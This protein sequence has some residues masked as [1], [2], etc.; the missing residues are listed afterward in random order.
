MPPK[1]ESRIILPDAPSDQESNPVMAWR[2]AVKIDTYA[3]GEPDSFPAFLERRVYQGSSGR[4]YPLPFRERIESVKEPLSWDAVHLE[5]NWVRLM[6]LPALGGRIHIGMDKTNGYDFFYRNN[7]VKPALVGLTGPWVSGGVE[8]NWPQ[9]H[10]PTTFLPTG[11]AIEREPDGAITVW[12][13]DHDPFARMKGMH[14]VRLRP[15][16]CLIELRVRLFNRSEDV[17]TFLWWANIAAR[18]GDRY[19]SF[20][21]A[22]VRY[23]AD[24]ARRATTRFPHA[25]RPYY[26]VDYPARAAARDPDADRLDWYRNITVPTSY[27]C[28]NSRGDFFGGYDHERQAGFVHWADHRIAPGKKQWTW[29]NAP[30]GWAWDANLTDGGGPYVELM[31]GVFTDN[32]PDFSYLVPGETRCFSQF[33]YPIQRI[34]PV[35]Q[36]TL[37]EAVRLDVEPAEDGTEVRVAVAVTA[38]RPVLGVRLE[39]PE[40]R[41]VWTVIAHAAPD[42]P[43]VEQVRLPGRYAPTELTLVIHRDGSDTLRW[44]HQGDTDV[45]EVPEPAAEPPS[46]GAIDSIEELYLTGLH[47]EQY[48]HATR[49]PEP[50]WRE[51]LARDP[52]YAAANLA[53]ARRR[54][55]AAEYAEAERHLRRALSRQTRLNAN[56]RDGE[57]HYLLGQVLRRQHRDADAY[58]A[59]AK[60]AWNAAWRVPAWLAMARLDAAAGRHGRALTLLDAMLRLDGEHLQ[61]RDLKALVLRRLGRDAEADGV[62]AATLAIDPLDSWARDLA[63]DRAAGDPTIG[64]DVALEYAAAGETPAALRILAAVADAPTPVGQVNVAPLAHYHRADLLYRGGDPVAARDCARLAATVDATNCL[65][66][67]LDD[68]DMLE[69]RCATAPRD[70]RAWALLGHWRYSVRRYADAVRAWETC[71]DI[72]GGDAVVLRNLAI[73]ANNVHR[74]AHLAADYYEQAITLA[75]PS[76]RLIYEADQLARR[77]GTEPAVRLARLAGL[78]AVVAERDDLTV[79][80]AELLTV[81]EQPRQALALL[82]NRR[83]HPWEG[84]EGRILAVWDETLLVLAGQ[85]MAA[86]RPDE[87][88]DHLKAALEPPATLGEARHPLA[89]RARLLLALGDAQAGAGLS[90]PARRSWQA[91]ATEAGDC[92]ATTTVPYSDLTYYSVLARRRLGEDPEDLVAG[93]AE[94]ADRMRAAPASI[95]YFATSLPDLLLFNEDGEDHKTTTVLILDAQLAAL[96]GETADARKLTAEALRRDPLRHTGRDLE[97]HLGGSNGFR[98]VPRGGPVARGL[99]PSNGS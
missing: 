46:P 66:S 11:S 28:L 57:G 41:A 30:F 27:M 37:D 21:P 3:V 16:S 20:F 26:G 69:R 2:E 19:Q 84:G 22:D 56:P 90:G 47:L 79:E 85:A 5:N 9:H 51:A 68:V 70:G 67:R 24:H 73:A 39:D 81:L 75:G 65:A 95:D 52:D 74:D 54:L 76:P 7:V 10:R 29:G 63:G 96:R 59:Y 97:K 61:G 78:A 98:G 4:I 64:L 92:P 12:C 45:A 87:A 33:C 17:Q 77:R 72:D 25:D 35:H 89:G 14:G 13:S 62:L 48:R 1:K 32:Q 44:C 55:V 58:D 99:D 71:V 36:A 43:V 60:A 38:E 18:A 42:R 82:A 49:S 31:A 83:F 80:F 94:F 34:G 53:L 6:L 15:D 91:A 40:G 93:L 50:Y 88:V 23:V 8:F 86:G